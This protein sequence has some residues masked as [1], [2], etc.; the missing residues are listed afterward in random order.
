MVFNVV[1][2]RLEGL[3]KVLG[4]GDFWLVMV[5]MLVLIGMLVLQALCGSDGKG[6]VIAAG[7]EEG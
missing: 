7:W 4:I 6:V 5:K 1:G 3:M 2:C